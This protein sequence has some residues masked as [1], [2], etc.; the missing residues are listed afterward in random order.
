MAEAATIGS[1][2]FGCD[3]VRLPA[4]D[5]DLRRVPPGWPCGRPD[6]QLSLADRHDV[7][8]QRHLSL[9]AEFFPTRPS[10]IIALAP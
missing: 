7:F 1:M 8:G 10:S 3:P 4:V 6:Q 9:G 2:N 5:G